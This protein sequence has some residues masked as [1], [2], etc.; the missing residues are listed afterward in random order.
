M[1]TA[2]SEYATRD[3]RVAED[4]YFFAEQNARLVRNAER[5]YRTMFAGHAESWNLRDTLM[6]TLD[7]LLERTTRRAGYARAVV[8]PG[9]LSVGSVRC[10]VAWSWTQSVLPMART[11]SMPTCIFPNTPGA[12]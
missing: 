11:C 3:G 1:R 10:R 8:S 5:Y 9:N 2:A 6:E 7:A 4:E 12:W